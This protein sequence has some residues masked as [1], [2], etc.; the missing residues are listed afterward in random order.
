MPLTCISE[1]NF[2]HVVRSRVY[3]Y[4]IILVIAL[5]TIVLVPMQGLSRI[6]TNTTKSSVEP[7]GTECNPRRTDSKECTRP[8]AGPEPE[9]C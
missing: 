9:V 8:T 1:I 7:T 5:L 2:K 4:S 6:G 3:I